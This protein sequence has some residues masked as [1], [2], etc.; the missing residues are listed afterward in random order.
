MLQI[1]L[2]AVSNKMLPNKDFYSNSFRHLQPD[3]LATAVWRSAAPQKCKIF[4]WLAKHRRLPTNAR[5]FQHQLATSVACPSCPLDEDVDHLLLTCHRARE[6]WLFFSPA[7]NLNGPCSFP[8]LLQRRCQSLEA[9]TVHLAIAWNI[10]KR[11][12]TLVFNGTDE[13]L[14]VAAKRCVEDVRLWA[15]R[16]K[17]ND[18]SSSLN[19]WCTRFDPP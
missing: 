19:M 5:R 10:W 11:R 13:P 3:E 15:Y 6:M 9:S 4:C 2:S 7:S 14:L 1:F 17:N 12:N 16:C 8:E 18:S